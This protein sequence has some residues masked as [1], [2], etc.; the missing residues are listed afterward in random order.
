MVAELESSLTPTDLLHKLKSTENSLGRIH[1]ERWGPREID[2]DLLYY[3]DEVYN[4]AELHLPHPEIANRRFVLVPM[5]EIAAEFY[6]SLHH[7]NIKELLH[8]CPDTNAVRKAL[9][10]SFYNEKDNLCNYLPKFIT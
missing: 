3:G 1:R 5:K 2:I 8:C 10:R 6:D 4:D 7:L 9:S